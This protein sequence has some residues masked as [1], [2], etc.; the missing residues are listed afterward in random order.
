MINGWLKRNT[1][2]IEDQMQNYKHEECAKTTY[3]MEANS[4]SVLVQ[5]VESYLRINPRTNRAYNKNFIH[6]Y[7]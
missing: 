1:T 6:I 7:T 5:S 3:W 2:L 4:R